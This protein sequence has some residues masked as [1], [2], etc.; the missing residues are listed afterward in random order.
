[1]ELFDK[2][3]TCAAL[4]WTMLCEMCYISKSGLDW[5]VCF[6]KHL[7]TNQAGAG[8]TLISDKSEPH[9]PQACRLPTGA[10]WPGKKLQHCICFVCTVLSSLYCEVAIAAQTCHW[11]QTAPAAELPSRRPNAALLQRGVTPRRSPHA[12]HLGGATMS[13]TVPEETGCTSRVQHTEAAPC[14]PP[15]Q[16][17]WDNIKWVNLRP[18]RTL[19]CSVSS[20]GHISLLVWQPMNHSGPPVWSL[21]PNI[22]HGHHRWCIPSVCQLLPWGH[23]SYIWKDRYGIWNTFTEVRCCDKE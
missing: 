12:G 1:M 6:T 13:S 4:W 16:H 9:V 11:A 23:A 19:Y 8:A 20:C 15:A 10:A 17:E 2:R 21:W 18:S 7:A 22:A 14:P 3:H 5:M